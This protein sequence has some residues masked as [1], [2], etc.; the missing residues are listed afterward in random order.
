MKDWGT[1]SEVHASY[2]Q[3]HP[4]TDTVEIPYGLV[5]WHDGAA[6]QWNGA[7]WNKIFTAFNGITSAQTDPA[8]YIHQTWCDDPDPLVHH[9]RCNPF[10]SPEP[11][12][13]S[14]AV[15]HPRHYNSHPSGIECITVVEHMGFNTGNAIKYIWRADEKGSALEDLEKARWYIEREI[16]RRKKLSE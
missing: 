6:F 9:E 7:G 1:M 8:I 5:W 12:V 16:T 3:A 15:D 2:R 11:V 13:N 14:S 4:D 10:V